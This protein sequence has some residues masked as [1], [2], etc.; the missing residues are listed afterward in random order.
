MSRKI[1]YKAGL[2]TIIAIVFALLLVMNVTR[3]YQMPDAILFIG[4]LILAI[5]IIVFAIMG[6]RSKAK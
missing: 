6:Y 2:Y 3:S 1:V 4:I 5:W